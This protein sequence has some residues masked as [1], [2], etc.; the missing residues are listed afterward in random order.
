MCRDSSLGI[1]FQKGFKDIGFIYIVHFL[2]LK[3]S[4]LFLKMIVYSLNEL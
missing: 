4:T 2:W 1:R 3:Y